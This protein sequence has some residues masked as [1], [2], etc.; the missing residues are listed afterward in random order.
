MPRKLKTLIKRQRALDKVMKKFGG[1]PFELGTNDCVQL[2]RFH[3]KA[4]GHKLPPTGKYA[5]AAQAAAQLK[6]QGAKNLE[7][8]LDK[9]LERIPPARML[10]G[11]L[12]MPPSDPDAPAAKIGTVMVAITPRKFLGWHPD[13]ETLAVMELLQ[14]DAAWRA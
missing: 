14:I 1:K 11:D 2:T 6:K 9:H 7:Q 5:T 12:A 3:L 13:H 10:P 4:L 8:L